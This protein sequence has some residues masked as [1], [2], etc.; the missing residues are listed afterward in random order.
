MY[1]STTANNRLLILSQQ[2]VGTTLQFLLRIGILENDIEDINSILVTGGFNYDN[3]K[4]IINKKILLSDLAKYRDI[5]LVIKSLEQKQTELTNS[6]I[7]LGNQK[8][9][10][11]NYLYNIFKVI[12]S[13]L[14]EIL[15]LVKK[16]NIALEYPKILLIYLSFDSNKEDNNKDFK[17]NNAPHNH[18]AKLDK[19][20]EEYTPI[21]EVFIIFVL[22]LS[23]YAIYPI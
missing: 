8:I 7:E 18:N 2:Q 11:E 9:V 20:K 3:N 5:K 13:N 17:D 12:P 16:I 1:V 22:L 19:Q 14:K 4:T 10:L 21:I 6:M 15:I 23:A